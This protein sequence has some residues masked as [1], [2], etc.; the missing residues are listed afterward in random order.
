VLATQRT[1][2]VKTR[3]PDDIDNSSPRPLATFLG[4]FSIGL[5]LAELCMTRTMERTTGVRSPGLLRGYGVREIVSGAGILTADRP[6]FWLWSRV[7]G[8]VIDLATLGAAYANANG[9]DRT[10]ALAS[11]AAV[12][13]VAALDVMCGVEHSRGND[14]R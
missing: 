13:G 5:G 1:H 8:D 2:A 12:A 6:A 4:L 7:A 14:G 11:A 10:R 9:D 3:L